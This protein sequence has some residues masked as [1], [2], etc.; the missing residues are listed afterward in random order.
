MILVQYKKQVFFD[1]YYLEILL[2]YLLF[3]VLISLL[4]T[5]F[6]VLMACFVVPRLCAYYQGSLID[7]IGHR[8]GYQSHDK[9]DS[10]KN[11]VLLNLL[12]IG[13]GMHNNHHAEPWNYNQG[14]GK[15]YEFD[16]SGWIIGRFL[17]DFRPR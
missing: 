3:I 1:K 8:W 7:I 2:S 14:G 13:G 10:S 4:S 15:W 9:C 6:T 16:L 17:N 11:N 12:T 5:S